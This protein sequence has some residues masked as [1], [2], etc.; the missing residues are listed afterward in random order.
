MTN[1][2]VRTAFL[3]PQMHSTR[4]FC[5]NGCCI[6]NILNE[7]I[8]QLISKVESGSIAGNDSVIMEFTELL[9]DF[10]GHY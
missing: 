3:S 9:M 8:K 4:S 2:K 7:G 10:S 5:R 6:R 1:C